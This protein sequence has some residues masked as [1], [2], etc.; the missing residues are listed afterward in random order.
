MAKEIGIFDVK[1]F[2]ADG[3]LLHEEEAHNDM[4]DEGEQEVLDVYLRGAT[5][6]ASFALRLFNDTPVETDNLA[7]LTGEP[8]GNG[9]VA[10]TIERSAVGWP[11]LG[12]DAGDYQ[13]TSKQ[14]TFDA[15][16]GSWGPVT[17]IAMVTAEGKLITAA[18]LSQ[19]RTLADGESLTVTYRIKQQ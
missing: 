17:H 7:A 6:P 4:L 14:V 15:S 10:Q 11:T 5:P 1:H 2:A 16:G 12:L 8:V 9:Y 3:S 13:A 18:A 19:A